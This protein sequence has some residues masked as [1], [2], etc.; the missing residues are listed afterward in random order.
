MDGES[1]G[2]SPGW[3]EPALLLASM[4]LCRCVNGTNQLWVLS[5]LDLET[6][7]KAERAGHFLLASMD[8]VML[9]QPVAPGRRSS[10]K[11]LFMDA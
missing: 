7:E 11:C 9:A 4:H 1:H 6:S 10:A 2:S 3:C 5:L 8:R